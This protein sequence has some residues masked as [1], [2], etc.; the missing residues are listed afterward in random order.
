[1]DGYIAITG[2][3]GSGKSYVCR[4]IEKRGISIYDC[5]A[6]AKRLMRTS[7]SLRRQL[8]ELI[9][10]SI[11]PTSSAGA[12][13]KAVIAQFLLAS[14]A[15]ARALNDIVHPAVALDFVQSGQ[16][17]L[18]SAILFQ[19]GFHH[20]VSFSHV[21]AVTAPAELRLQRVMARDGI[22]RNK[23]LEWMARQWPQEE[24]L[25]LADYEIVND[26]LQP[27][28]PQI[29]AILSS[30]SHKSPSTPSTP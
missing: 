6:A 9:P 27:L 11:P 10:G 12:L 23:A 2:G 19:S 26:G 18:E 15:N 1:M 3:I 30:L 22:S 21:I 4:L 7:A 29:D 28:L 20:R 16:Q 17:W 13:D 25:K 14:E 8:Q 5:D 24:T